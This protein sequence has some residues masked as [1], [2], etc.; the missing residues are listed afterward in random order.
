[1]FSI[2][3]LGRAVDRPA[4]AEARR[5][6]G[7]R[8]P[9]SGETA[10]PAVLVCRHRQAA[11][12]PIPGLLPI[13][14]W[15]GNAG[16]HQSFR[17]Q[18][19]PTSISPSTRRALRAIV[20][21]TGIGLP[22]ISLV[23]LGAMWLYQSG[24]VLHWAM[25]VLAIV[26]GATAIEL[27]WLGRPRR[28]YE[29]EDGPAAPEPELQAPDPRWSGGERRAWAEVERIARDVQP[30][31]LSTR[32]EVLGL[33]IETIRAV[34]SVLHEGRRNSH[35]QFTVPEAL[36]IVE[37]VSGRLG[38]FV[39]EN[40]PL[41]DRLTVA[42]AMTLYRWRGAIDV[43][44]KAFDIWRLIRLANPVTAATYELRERM[45]RQLYEWGRDHVVGRI[46]ETYVLEVGRAA[47][48]LYSGRMEPHR[49]DLDFDGPGIDESVTGP[50]LRPPEMPPSEREPRSRWQALWSQTRGAGRTIG[51]AIFRRRRR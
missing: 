4:R 28:G 11:P 47:I 35:L 37:Q 20:I 12:A 6:V 10:R 38:T 2:R 30:D 39:A 40:I 34:A 15:A 1:M 25:A 9:G 22:T 51:G 23:P 21:T 46:A 5:R 50:P 16:G 14:S 48:D 17:S 42:H 33:A 18:R 13:A 49:H 36:A 41:G 31:R 26:G 44:E 29:P 24:Y 8:E 3:E 45:S 19:R 43:A 27:H 32:D 7:G